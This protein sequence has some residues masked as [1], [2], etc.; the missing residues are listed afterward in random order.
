MGKNFAN[1]KD[2]GASAVPAAGGLRS[3]RPLEGA[4][5]VVPDDDAD[6]AEVLDARDVGDDVQLDLTQHVGYVAVLCT[7][8]HVRIMFKL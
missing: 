3:G 2:E 5:D 1:L 6:G 4:D 7:N 8:R